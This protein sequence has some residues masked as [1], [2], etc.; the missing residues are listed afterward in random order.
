MRRHA[1]GRRRRL[2]GSKIPLVSIV[3][4]LLLVA[5]GVEAT[6]LLALGAS[7]GG[8]GGGTSPANAVVSTGTGAAGG[9]GGADADASE[10]G[11]GGHGGDESAS[12]VL[13]GIVP[14]PLLDGVGSTAADELQ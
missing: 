11:G 7:C 5:I 9:D 13:V 3:N 10:S 4:R 8:T 12:S 2:R 6:L 14:N 1:T